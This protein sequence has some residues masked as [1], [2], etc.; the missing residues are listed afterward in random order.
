MVLSSVGGFK[1][2]VCTA[3]YKSLEQP[4]VWCF[5]VS[6]KFVVEGADFMHFSITERDTD[7]SLP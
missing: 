4:V 2:F 6:G 7:F 3:G 5:I 1:D